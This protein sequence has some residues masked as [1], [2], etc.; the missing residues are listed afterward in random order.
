MTSLSGQSQFVLVLSFFKRSQASLHIFFRHMIYLYR[1]FC[2]ICVKCPKYLS[3]VNYINCAY[4]VLPLMHSG[5]SFSNLYRPQFPQFQWLILLLC[6]Q[7]RLYRQHCLQQLEL[8]SR[9]GSPQR[10]VHWNSLTLLI[11]TPPHLRHTGQEMT[12]LYFLFPHLI[13][14]ICNR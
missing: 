11:Y 3:I 5:R 10:T 7:R 8:V 12:P 1:K 13:F 14:I 6:L 4:F 2:Y 9:H